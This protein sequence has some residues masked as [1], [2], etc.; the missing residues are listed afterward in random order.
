MVTPEM[1]GLRV[2]QKN[3]YGVGVLWMR[4]GRIALCSKPQYNGSRGPLTGDWVLGSHFIGDRCWADLKAWCRRRSI[5]GFQ[6]SNCCFLKAENQPSVKMVTL[7]K[8]W[9]HF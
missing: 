7:L 4:C 8:N 2:V 6:Q 5:G 3:A 1:A 9:G